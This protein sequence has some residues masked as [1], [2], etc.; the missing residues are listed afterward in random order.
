M[1]LKT[2]F[3]IVK[4]AYIYIFIRIQVVLNR[5]I[6]DNYLLI[7]ADGGYSNHYYNMIFKNF[8]TSWCHGFLRNNNKMDVCI[9]IIIKVFLSIG[10]KTFHCMSLNPQ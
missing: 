2:F 3:K 7:A 4:N 1:Q 6:A 5:S 9:I 10:I 8:Q